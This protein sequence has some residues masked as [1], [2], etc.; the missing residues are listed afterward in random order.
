MIE[1]RPLQIATAQGLV[2]GLLHDTPGA[3]HGVVL[4]GDAD[5][6]RAA[7]EPLWEEL[8]LYLRAAGVAVFQ[9]WQPRQDEIARRAYEV[10]AGVAA[11]AHEGV[12]RVALVEWSV[13]V[14]AAA[15]ARQA[16]AEVPGVASTVAGVATI[17]TPPVASTR[18]G[19]HLRLIRDDEPRTVA[20]DQRAPAL[21]SRAPAPDELVLF[22]QPEHAAPRGPQSALLLE[23]LY[24]WST[25][26]LQ[27]PATGETRPSVPP[28]LPVLADG[29]QART[30]VGSHPRATLHLE[31][32]REWEAVIAAL[33]QRDAPRAASVQVIAESSLE[34]DTARLLPPAAVW[35]QL[36]AQGQRDWLHRS[37]R[38]WRHTLLTPDH[39][40]DAAQG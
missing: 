13:G 3:R 7:Q 21:P 5:S 18:H 32:R 2:R 24:G 37:M 16:S 4:V 1:P 23:T 22:P 30:A 15:I 33:A 20:P 8:S 35:G 36:D 14:A 12:A 10:L 17:V 40:T 38:A 6:G 26:L 27:R 9:L 25:A 31:L 29:H 34:A 19:T 39:P 11:L 28:A